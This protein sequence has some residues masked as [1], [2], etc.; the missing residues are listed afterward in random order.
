LTENQA[1][2]EQGGVRTLV[3]KASATMAIVA[4]D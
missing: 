2:A 3:M 4:A 1:V